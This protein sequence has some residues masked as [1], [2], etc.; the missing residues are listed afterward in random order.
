MEISNQTFI[1][2]T[3]WTERIGFVAALATIRFM[4]KNNVSSKI[5]KK[6]K[7]VIDGWKKLAFKN[8][9]EITTNKFYSM[10]TF[11]FNYEK[12]NDKLN[13][14]FTKYMLEKGYIAT[15][16]MFI[17]FAHNENEIKKYLKVCN[18]VFKKIKQDLSNKV[19]L[20]KITSRKMT[21]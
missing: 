19:K 13:T 12:N 10:P 15:N 1:S 2:S 7:K 21:Y 8:Q 14:L 16:Y 18:V 3:A 6:G 4:K 17:T 20:K 9:L 11:S 5:M